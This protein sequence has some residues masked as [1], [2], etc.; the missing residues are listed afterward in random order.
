M[1]QDDPTRRGVLAA[2]GTLTGFAMAAQ[3]VVAQTVIQTDTAGLEARDVQ[4]PAADRAIPAYMARPAGG[5]AAPVVLVVPEIFG[6]HEHIKDVARRLAKAGHFAVAIEPFARQGDPT[7]Q[8]DMQALI[9]DIVSRTPD[10]QVMSDLDAAVAW[11]KAQGGDTGR[12]AITGFCWGG[13]IVWLY[14]AHNPGLKAGA[15]WYGRLEGETN[16]LQPRH[17]IGVV[18]EL[19]APVLGLYGGADTGIP[20]A[21]VER[22]RAALREAGQAKSEIIVFDGVP[23]AF[24]ADYRPSYREAAAKEGWQRMLAFFQANGAG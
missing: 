24:N 7:R 21:S 12:L 2:A 4:I 15:A 13:R 17:P 10:A 8:A 11:A 19:K 22:M 5:T 1:A 18:R 23:H 16:P 3:P 20:V 14:A 9:R 6:L